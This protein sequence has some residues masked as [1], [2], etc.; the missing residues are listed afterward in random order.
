MAW[1]SVH[2]LHSQTNLSSFIE[3]NLLF[4]FCLL[5]LAEP[6]PLAAAIT[7]QSKKKKKA[8]QIQIAEE[9]A[10]HASFIN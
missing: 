6:L 10:L 7:H 4:F 9:P 5:L 2:S 8:N 1:R 3:F